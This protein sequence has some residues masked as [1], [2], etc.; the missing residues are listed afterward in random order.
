MNAEVDAAVQVLLRLVDRGQEIAVRAWR[1][2]ATAAPWAPRRRA[3]REVHPAAG[4]DG[5][6]P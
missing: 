3:T 1:R 6:S 4:R 2:A 5:A